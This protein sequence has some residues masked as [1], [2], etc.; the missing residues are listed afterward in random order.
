MNTKRGLLG[1]LMLMAC[2]F[3]HSEEIIPVPTTAEIT[4]GI[5]KVATQY[6]SSI[7]CSVSDIT[8]SDIAAL[9][10]YTAFENRYDA[11]YAVFWQ[12]DIG[13][14]GGSGTVSNNISVIT[15]GTNDTYLVS[16]SESSPSIE[17][18]PPVATITKFLGNT[19][20]TLVFSG[21]THGAEDA[22]CCPSVPMKFSMKT[23]A[24]GNWKVVNKKLITVK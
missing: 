18:S 6:A 11:R 13:C 2:S 16:S 9:I 4:Q 3:A 19:K 12:G 1:C 14:S 21:L 5:I 8:A 22:R 23:D 24:K 17:F 20:D 15:V 7:A 10:P